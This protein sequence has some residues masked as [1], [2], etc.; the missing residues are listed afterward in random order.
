MH[1]RK[2]SNKENIKLALGFLALF[3]GIMILLQ[4]PAGMLYAIGAITYA[5][6]N[7]LSSALLSMSFSISVFAYL[8]LFKKMSFKNVV[9]AL[10]LDRKRLTKRALGLGVALFIT[11]FAIEALV[12]ALESYFHVTISTNVE[13]LMAGAPLW[14][15]V[16]AAIVA[17]TNEEIMFRGFLVPRLGIIISA[18]L[19]A[20]PHYVYGSTYEIEV[21]AAFIFGLLAGYI[22]KKTGSLYASIVAHML[23]NIIAVLALLA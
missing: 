1:A 23:V 13:E 7:F 17:P 9:K 10:G 2:Q 11:V 4:V 3:L 22:Y 19:F 20:I 16:F 15:Y 6:L 18:V 5:G 8:M 12:T 21:I 14:F